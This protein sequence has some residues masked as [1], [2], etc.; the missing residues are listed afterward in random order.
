MPVSVVLLGTG[1][2]RMEPGRSGAATAVVVDGRPYL[3]DCGPGIGR[4]IA[5]AH[6][7]GIEGT[8][9]SGFL[10]AF[11]T[12]LHSDH[13][14]GLPDLALS[15]W[16]FD[17]AEPLEVYGPRGTAAL[18]RAVTQ[19]YAADVAKRLLSEPVKERGHEMV[20]HDVGPGV[21][22]RDDLVTV[23]AFGVQHGDWPVDAGPHPAMGYRIRT[24]DRTIVISGDTGPF[25][26][27]AEA[28]AGADVLV[29]E[30]YASAGLETRPREW[31]GY[32]RRSHTSGVEVGRVAKAAAPGLLVTTHQLLWHVGEEE[33]MDEIRSTYD[34][35]VVHGHDLDVV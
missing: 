7:V 11:L 28:Y 19:G 30:V 27:M 24:A 17:R 26:G 1:T 3:F 10:R 32:H 21:V 29:H 13:T 31:Q 5:D 12:H 8:A 22:Y 33:L 6:E 16:M 23:E 20:G 25:A 2:P 35:P 14:T 9:F 34:G 18:T 4:R 15:S